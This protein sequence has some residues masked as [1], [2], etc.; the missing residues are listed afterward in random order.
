MGSYHTK[1]AITLHKAV[2]YPAHKSLA[3]KKKTSAC[4]ENMPLITPREQL[5]ARKMV[6]H[7][8]LI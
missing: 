3:L 4:S 2:P 6:R 8:P 5:E 1:E 7:K